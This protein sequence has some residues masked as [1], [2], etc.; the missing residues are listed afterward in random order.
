M[1]ILGI[2]IYTCVIHFS[3]SNISDLFSM[4]HSWKQNYSHGLSLQSVLLQHQ[5]GPESFTDKRCII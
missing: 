1:C 3:M 4:N 5:S 2:V